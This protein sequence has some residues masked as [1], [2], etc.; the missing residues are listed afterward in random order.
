M[1]SSSVI[2]PLLALSGLATA[3]LNTTQSYKLR[4]Q[5]QPGSE[6]KTEFDNLYL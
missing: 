5:L 3:A 1:F 6:G 4:T 2:V